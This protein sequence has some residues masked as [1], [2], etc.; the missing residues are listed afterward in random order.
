MSSYG[1]SY[2]IIIWFIPIKYQKSLNLPNQR[3][4]YLYT[5][6][7][8]TEIHV[9]N[10]TE[11]YGGREGHCR[12]GPSHC[13][14]PESRHWPPKG[15]PLAAAGHRS[16]ATSANLFEKLF[17]RLTRPLS[18][19]HAQGISLSVCLCHRLHDNMHRHLAWWVIANGDQIQRF[20][21]WLSDSSHVRTWT[22]Q[23][24]LAHA[25]EGL[26]HNLNCMQLLPVLQPDSREI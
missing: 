6:T 1:T 10:S 5:C 17:S 12:G 26:V 16:S 22:C 2:S 3:K 24:T 15:H 20:S 21:G 9:N 8:E 13:V 18:C 25:H 23:I 11:F 19:T 7:T 4:K 14:P